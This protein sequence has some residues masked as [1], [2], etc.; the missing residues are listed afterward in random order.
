MPSVFHGFFSRQNYERHVIMTQEQEQI[1]VESYIRLGTYKA[2]HDELGHSTTT[3]FKVI[4]AHNLAKGMGGNQDKQRKVTNEQLL[5][6]VKTMTTSEIAARY[7]LHE[8]NVLRRCKKLG[9]KPFGSGDRL[10]GLRKNWGKK[11]EN[12]KRGGNGGNGKERIW[13]GCWH[14]VSSQAEKCKE[15]HPGFE[16]LETKGKRVRLK[17]KVCGTIIE[18]ADSTFREKNINC[19]HCEERIKGQQS[20]NESRVSL[21]RALSALAE[22]K[23]PKTCKLCGKEFHSQ[24]L[25]AEY[26]SH[27]CK[28]RNRRSTSIRKRCRKYGAYYDASVKP[29]KIFAR[30]HYVCQ[31]CGLVCDT[32]DKRWGHF[33]PYSPT[34]DHIIALANGG[35]H[36]WEN[37]QCA[38]AICNSY[39]RDLLTV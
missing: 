7:S 13:G 29:S 24:Y 17:C 32:H 16:Y 30:D 22:Y 14:Y 37:V 38:H 36:V 19:E 6:A 39:K 5:E 10:S 15:K 21:I 18:R 4:K 27:S 26:C 34:V 25:N 28:K 11:N 31:I 2:V 20:L 8:T 1:I 12:L 33:G 23:K 9:V 3:I 35:N